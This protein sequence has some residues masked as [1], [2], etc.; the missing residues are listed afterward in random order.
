MDIKVFKKK[1]EQSYTK[2]A[3]VVIFDNNEVDGFIDEDVE[4]VKY[5]DIK[6]DVSYKNSFAATQTQV[7]N[8][9]VQIKMFL[10]DEYIIPINSKILITDEK[11]R[12]REYKSSSIP[13]VYDTHQEITL[14][15]VDRSGDVDV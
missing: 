9:S 15:E 13:A 4:I 14:Q 6:C 10:S 3:D 1:L 12:Q 5:K 2:H 7:P 8:A 11:G